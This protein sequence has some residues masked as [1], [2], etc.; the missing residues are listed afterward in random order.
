MVK[1]C[2]IALAVVALLVTTVRADDPAIKKDFGDKG[3]P[4]TYVPIDIC[5][6]PVYM[7]VG[8]YVQVKECHKRELILKQVDCADIGQSKFPCYKGCE[9][10]QARANFPAIFGGNFVKDSVNGKI[11]KHDPKVTFTD[12]N[13]QIDGSTGGWEKLEICLETW[14]VE[15]W[16]SDVVDKKLKV[17]EL[18]ITVKPPD[19][20]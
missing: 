8:H 6:M 4:Y 12:D 11:F 5:K 2:I 1:K 17:G 10:F 14:E 18:T 13:N 19:G 20:P 7:E 9:E 3:W 16:K 15:V